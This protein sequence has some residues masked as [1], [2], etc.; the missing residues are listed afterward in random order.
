MTLD[1]H[2]NL[3]YGCKVNGDAV[4]SMDDVPPS[5]MNDNLRSSISSTLFTVPLRY[6]SSARR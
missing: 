2:F 3:F 4:V 5:P 6:T 1:S